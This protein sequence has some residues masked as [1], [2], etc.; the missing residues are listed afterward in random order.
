MGTPCAGVYKPTA[1]NV[2]WVALNRAFFFLLNL[3]KNFKGILCTSCNYAVCALTHWEFGLSVDCIVIHTRFNLLWYIFPIDYLIFI[4][5]HSVS[6][7][8]PFYPQH[9]K[10]QAMSSG[11]MWG[12]GESVSSCI[13]FIDYDLFVGGVQ[14]FTACSFPELRNKTHKVSG[15]EAFYHTHQRTLKR[16]SPGPSWMLSAASIRT[17]LASHFTL[18]PSSWMLWNVHDYFKWKAM[19]HR[20]EKKISRGCSNL[21]LTI[22]DLYCIS[23]YSKTKSSEVELK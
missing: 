22:L 1:R 2:A 12:L 3:W 21:E 9:L 7:N 19:N 17:G 15:H 10:S 8:L 23:L 4:W 5:Y 14:V 13:T 20:K 18:S 16:L 6:I 11:H